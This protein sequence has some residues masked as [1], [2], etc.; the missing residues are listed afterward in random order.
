[1]L[2]TVWE[3]VLNMMYCW[4][5]V[6]KMLR[7]VIKMLKTLVIAISLWLFLIYLCLKLLFKI[8]FC[9]FLVFNRKFSNL[10]KMNLNL[11]VLTLATIYICFC[12]R[13]CNCIKQIEKCNHDKDCDKRNNLKNHFCTKRV[14]YV[15]NRTF[16]YCLP[17][18]GYF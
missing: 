18:K 6:T 8:F 3:K 16:R 1:M 7:L 13:N 4:W 15:S 9:L 14:I 17:K 5:W 10:N 11:M 12:S 2:K